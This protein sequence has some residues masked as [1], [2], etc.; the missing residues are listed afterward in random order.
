[1]REASLSPAKRF[2]RSII[3]RYN[4]KRYWKYR[5]IVVD[6]G[7]SS[8]IGGDVVAEYKEGWMK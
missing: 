4:H 7:K 6:Q 1:M 8:R 3:Q 2:L 5:S